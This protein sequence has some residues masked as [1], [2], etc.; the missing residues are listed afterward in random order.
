MSLV[1]P[2]YRWSSCPPTIC[3][4]LVMDA[5][6][7][8]AIPH[9]SCRWWRADTLWPIWLIPGVAPGIPGVVGTGTLQQVQCTRSSVAGSAVA[10]FAR[11]RLG[12]ALLLFCDATRPGTWSASRQ[13]SSSDPGKN[14]KN[15]NPLPQATR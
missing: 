15:K 6:G 9:S 3:L 12:N 4:N 5:L 2:R 13:C 10:R 11:N 14:P 8:T 7:L 1:S